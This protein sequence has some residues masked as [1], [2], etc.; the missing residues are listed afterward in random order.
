MYI[1]KNLD[2]ICPVRKSSIDLKIR[3]WGAILSIV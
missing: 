2:A 1:V 3:E